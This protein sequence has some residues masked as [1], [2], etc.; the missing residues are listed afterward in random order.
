MAVRIT[1]KSTLNKFLPNIN[2]KFLTKAKS[3][4]ADQIIK[5]ITSG[6]SP[7]TGKRFKGYSREYAKIKGRVQPVD[8]TRTGEMLES[9]RVSTAGPSSVD[10]KFSD[11]IAFYHNTSGAGVNRIIRRLLPDRSGEEF[12]KSIQNRIN[13][14]IETIVSQ[15]VAR[16]N[17]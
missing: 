7:V 17:R 8:M 14:S 2:K 1:I 4:I 16:Q 6:T 15:E 9:L 13:K 12:T 10:I 11:I 3:N 5:T